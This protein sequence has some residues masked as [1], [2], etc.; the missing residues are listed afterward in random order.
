VRASGDVDS[1]LWHFNSLTDEEVDQLEDHLA[2]ILRQIWVEGVAAVKRM[3]M[4]AATLDK[5]EKQKRAPQTRGNG[6]QSLVLGGG[7][8]GNKP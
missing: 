4:A 5:L 3:D 1:G 6:L 8:G 7:R 2:E